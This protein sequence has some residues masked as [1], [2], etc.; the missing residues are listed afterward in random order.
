MKRLDGSV[1]L[2]RG[3]SIDQMASIRSRLLEVL[4]ARLGSRALAED[5]LQAAFVRWMEKGRT[6][7]KEESAVAWLYRLANNLLVDV[8]RRQAAESRM[9]GSFSREV[10]LHVGEQAAEED[11]PCLCVG[12]LLPSLRPE[13]QRALRAVDVD[14]RPIAEW[15]RKEQISTNN[16]SVRLHRARRALAQRVRAVCGPCAERMCVGCDCS[17]SGLAP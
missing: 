12:R 1:S 2:P 5:I 15:A 4:E 14:G 6:L 16:A 9:L 3:I 7:R 11:S 8:R 10:D 13:Y 17:A